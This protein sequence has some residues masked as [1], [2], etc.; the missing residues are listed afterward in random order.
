[1]SGFLERLR[2]ECRVVLV[3]PEVKR[4]YFEERFGNEHVI[5]EG[6]PTALTRRDLFLRELF[7]AFTW[8]DG[9]NIKKRVERYQSKR[10]VTFLL[11]FVPGF[12]FRN[13]KSV[14][15]FLRKLD[16]LILRSRRFK[17]V[18]NKY[19]PWLVFSTDPQNE[20]DVRLLHEA[21]EYN[22][23]TLAMIRS[24]DNL[25]SKGLLRSLPDF[26]LVNNGIIKRELERYNHV[27]P[28]CIAIIG[29]PHYDRYAAYLRQA[30]DTREA[31]LR[32]YG[33]D[34]LKQTV[35][36]A[37]FGDRYI[38][39]NRLDREVLEALSALDCNIIVRLPPT[40]TVS[41]DAFKSQRAHVVFDKTGIRPWKEIRGD[42]PSKANEISEEDD[43]RL[44]K[45]LA[46]TDVLVTGHSTIAIDAAF[47][48]LPVVVVRYD[49]ESRPYLDSVRRYFDFEYYRPVTES[50][51]VAFAD[52]PEELLP[53]VVAYLRDPDLHAEGRAQIIREEVTYTDGGAS[54][55]LATA[56]LSHSRKRLFI[57]V[58]EGVEAK[59]L[60]RTDFFPIL[61]QDRDI[62]TVLLMK[63]DDRIEL[64]RKELGERRLYYERLPYERSLGR[65]FDR[66]FGILKFMLLNTETT[67]LRRRMAYETSGNVFSY[68]FFSFLSFL[69]ARRFIR[70]ALRS[71]D[72]FLVRPSL[73]RP[74]FVRYKPDLVFLAHL[75]EEPE[76]HLLREARRH[77]VK[78]LGLVNSWD[79]VTAR[80]IM[81]LLP[82]H[83]AVF[84]SVVRDE[85]IQYNDMAPGRISVV[86]IPQYDV[87]FKHDRAFS[88]E[89]FLRGLGVPA[90]H[91]LIVFAP[92]GRSFNDTSWQMIDRLQTLIEEGTLGEKVSL[93]VR[94]QPNDFLEEEELK[95]RPWLRYQYPG[96][97]FSAERGVDW[98]MD[99][100]DI[101]L[102]SDTLACMSVLVCYASSISVDALAFDKPVINIGYEID[103]QSPPLKQPTQH[104]KFTHYNKVLKTGG[105]KFVR[106]ET[107]L[108]NALT[109][110]L[111]EPQK[112]H[113][114]RERL[115]RQQYEFTDGQSGARLA[116]L[117]QNT[118]KG[119]IE[120]RH[121]A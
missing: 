113:D 66:L 34:P 116:H 99:K 73:Y 54:E 100:Y 59:N 30:P 119:N 106:S 16:P 87:Y 61:Q 60:L 64:Y 80:A 85:L 67:R 103:T 44:M 10:Y 19:D 22:V 12:L 42:G 112:D 50:G 83:A 62:E 51:G 18:L 72:F 102:L 118:L 43:A 17:E 76:I 101:E 117:V 24:W 53:A 108:V 36:F 3:V 121:A 28:E 111:A 79:K 33:L 37:P 84:N 104:F 82:D 39:G 70:K 109:A 2:E 89:D 27:N 23:K 21:K 92:F 105:I 74:W 47:F 110:Y 86:G 32:S 20:L 25:T 107:E 58:F 120:S 31:V 75:F 11:S 88:C 81:R 96:I 7:L 9:L 4:H 114:G 98:D 95:N 46:H 65:G 97:R 57:S 94:F 29:V 14:V 93:L 56:V 38:R 35:L 63:S 1:M 78:T 5:V 115:L 15:A 8:T 49:S 13:A 69:I 41:L 91:R 68:A 90:D 48:D 71:L 26:F 52:Q 77:G 55:R 6:I 45:V 40:D